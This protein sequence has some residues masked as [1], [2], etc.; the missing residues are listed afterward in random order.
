MRSLCLLYDDDD[1][2]R[3]SRKK[4]VGLG[5][6]VWS[7]NNENKKKKQQQQERRREREYYKNIGVKA[8][9]SRGKNYV[10]FPLFFLFHA[11]RLDVFYR[12][13]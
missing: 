11:I 6:E 5:R 3:I 9:L 4:D 8:G 10:E 7:K 2:R 13:G 1:D 12:R